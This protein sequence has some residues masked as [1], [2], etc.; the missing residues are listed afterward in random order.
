MKR[1]NIQV[2]SMVRQAIDLAE[3]NLNQ[4]YRKYWKLPVAC[5]AQCDDLRL[6]MQQLDAARKLLYGV[7]LREQIIPVP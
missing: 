4:E 2:V 7:E 5:Q 6:A 1:L 3:T